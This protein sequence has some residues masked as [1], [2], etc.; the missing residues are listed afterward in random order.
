MCVTVKNVG[1]RCE[2]VISLLFTSASNRSR[3]ESLL[4]HID[5]EIKELL[6]PMHVEAGK[7]FSEYMIY[8]GKTAHGIFYRLVKGLLTRCNRYPIAIAPGHK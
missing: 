4:V 1:Q 5:M 8:R 3:P 2:R 7:Q 6:T